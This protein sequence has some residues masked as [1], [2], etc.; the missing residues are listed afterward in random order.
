MTSTLL[1][2]IN[3][4]IYALHNPAGLHVGNFKWIQGQWKFKAVGYG[5]SGQVMPGEGP[6]TH[7]HNTTFDPLDED[8]IRT[9]FFNED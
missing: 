7:R 5:P 6:L 9:A 1:T 3:K 2:S 4:G 8:Q